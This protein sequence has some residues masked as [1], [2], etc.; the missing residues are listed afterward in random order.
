M[1]HT[2]TKCI[3]SLHGGPLGR[4]CCSV[5]GCIGTCRYRERRR[6]IRHTVTLRALCPP[7]PTNPPDECS[8]T[9]PRSLRFSSRDLGWRH[10]FF[11]IKKVKTNEN[12][13]GKSAYCH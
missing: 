3:T 6:I 8:P 5:H 13:L 9:P 4:S 12:M 10:S 2:S 7:N 1:R 11:V